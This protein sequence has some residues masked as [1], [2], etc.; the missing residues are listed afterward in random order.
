MQN[1]A[2]TKIRFLPR[3][4][5]WHS[6]EGALVA[7]NQMLDWGS[8]ALSR[9][10][11]VVVRR[12]ACAAGQVSL[13]VRGSIRSQRCGATVPI[14]SDWKHVAP[15]ACGPSETQRFLS[16]KGYGLILVRNPWNLGQ[17]E[18]V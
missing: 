17:G 3:D 2:I 5:L 18:R 16:R 9:V 15:A 14:A 12:I 10:P 11:A 6:G 13:N 8:E 4:L 7:H 1:N